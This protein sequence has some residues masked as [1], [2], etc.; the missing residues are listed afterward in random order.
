M[1]C[2]RGPVNEPSQLITQGPILEHLSPTK[3]MGLLE[4]PFDVYKES[5]LEADPHI[6]SWV[7]SAISEEPRTAA[8]TLHLPFHDCFNFVSEKSWTIELELVKSDLES[9]FPETVSCA[10][11]LAVDATDSVLLEVQMG[12]KDSLSASKAAAT[13]NTRAPNSS[14]V[15]TLLQNLPSDQFF[16]IEDD[17]TREIAESYRW[18][19]YYS[20]RSTRIP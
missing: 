6:L 18:I 3:I 14:N 9:V 8:S 7:E 17:R 15:R 11:I 19:H 10:D 12:R 4:G 13:G 20:L 16:V 2:S 5:C 1:D